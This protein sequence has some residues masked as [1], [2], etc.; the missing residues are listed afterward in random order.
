MKKTIAAV[1]R[2]IENLKK[3]FGAEM[4]GDNY[5]TIVADQ[6]SG[7][8]GSNNL[9]GQETLKYLAQACL[10]SMR[11]KK[12]LGTLS[13]IK[14]KFARET[15]KNLIK[16]LGVSRSYVIFTEIEE[17]RHTDAL[18]FGL[19]TIFSKVP[20]AKVPYIMQQIEAC[21]YVEHDPAFAGIADPELQE[22]LQS[23]CENSANHDLLLNAA[24]RARA[25]FIRTE[26]SL[27]ASK[28]HAAG[29]LSYPDCFALVHKKFADRKKANSVTSPRTK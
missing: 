12:A 17:T 15:A 13:G 20:L 18:E 8:L 26:I 25:I 6:V 23:L 4:V 5:S 1:N 2:E 19:R 28:I 16:T 27:L 24:R 9:D 7:I 29:D 11:D 22:R 10:K 3:I 14:S 21:A